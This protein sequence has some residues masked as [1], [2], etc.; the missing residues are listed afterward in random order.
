MP[1]VEP[2]IAASVLVLGLLVAVQKKMPWVLAATL[3]GGRISGETLAG[4]V[5]VSLADVAGAASL[6]RLR[7]T[8]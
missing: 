3:A 4:H 6:A 7:L 2:M 1:G 5:A 8:R